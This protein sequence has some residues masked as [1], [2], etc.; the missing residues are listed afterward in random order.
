M[1]RGFKPKITLQSGS[2]LITVTHFKRIH[3]NLCKDDDRDHDHD[4]TCCQKLL[5]H[6]HNTFPSQ[7]SYLATL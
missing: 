4:A 7:F 5:F 2:K 6:L 1:T 3:S